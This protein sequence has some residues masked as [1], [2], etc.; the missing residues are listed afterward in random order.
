[1]GVGAD[2]LLFEGAGA[3]QQLSLLFA[4]IRTFFYFWQVAWRDSFCLP[5][6]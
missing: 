4:F 1:M 2:V 5:Y 3:H 6:R